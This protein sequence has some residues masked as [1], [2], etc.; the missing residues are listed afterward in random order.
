MVSSDEPIFTVRNL[1]AV[2]AFALCNKA[3]KKVLSSDS[4]DLC[5]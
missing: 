2:I 3:I 1:S 5:A 4:S